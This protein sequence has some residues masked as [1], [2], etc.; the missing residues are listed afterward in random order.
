[1]LAKEPEGRSSG[2]KLSRGRTKGSGL[3]VLLSRAKA[4]VWMAKDPFPFCSAALV[5]V[6]SAPFISR[7][8]KAEKETKRDDSP[9]SDIWLRSGRLG[10]PTGGA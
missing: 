4:A 9:S 5:S 3:R 10:I 1:M 6:L 8:L 2:G 7:G